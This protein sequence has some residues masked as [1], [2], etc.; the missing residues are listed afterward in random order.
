MICQYYNCTDTARYETRSRLYSDE[1]LCHCQYHTPC[2]RTFLTRQPGDVYTNR[3]K[4]KIN[5]LF[6]PILTPFLFLADVLIKEKR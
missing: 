3:I 1:K 5:A 2:M 4:T 6:E